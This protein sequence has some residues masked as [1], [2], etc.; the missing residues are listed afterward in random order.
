MTAINPDTPDL[1]KPKGLGLPWERYTHQHHWRNADDEFDAAKFGMWLFLSTEVLLFAGIFVAYAI[2]RMMHPQAFANGS[3]YLDVK[4]GGLNT[5]VLLLSSWTVAMSVRCAQLNQQKWLRINLIITLIC[6]ILFFVI[7]LTQEYT[8]KW[9]DG[10]RP[11]AL[12]D[13]PYVSD[14]GILMTFAERQATDWSLTQLEAAVKQQFI[15]NLSQAI[16]DTPVQAVAG[17]KRFFHQALQNPQFIVSLATG[18]WCETAKLKLQSAGFEVD[19]VPMASSNYHH[20]GLLSTRKQLYETHSLGFS[21]L[22]NQSEGGNS[23]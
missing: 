7:K 5:V 22:V 18:G 17:A 13:Y 3:H 1:A 19:Q 15:A 20:L 21:Q 10:K 16:A 23:V 14:R 9:S 4:W 12:F 8:P 6:A 11:G 2:L